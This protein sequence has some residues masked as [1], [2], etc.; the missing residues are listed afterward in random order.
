MKALNELSAEK[1][2]PVDIAYF[3]ET[4]E[5]GEDT[6]EYRISFKLYENGLTRDLEMDYGDFVIRGQARRPRRVRAGRQ[7]DLQPLGGARGGLCRRSHVALGRAKWC[8]CWPTTKKNFTAS[9]P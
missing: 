6:P 7:V 8:Q 9:P 4:S 1:F 2:W 5:G 3:D